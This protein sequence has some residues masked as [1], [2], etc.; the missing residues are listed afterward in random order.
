M[1]YR[2]SE[3]T[4]ERNSLRL[5]PDEEV[6]RALVAGDERAMEV[7]FARYYRMVMR[8]AL[9]IVRDPGEAQDV[10]QIVFTDF[11]RAAKLFDVDKGSLKTWLLQYAYGRSVNRKQSLK[12]RNFYQEN[13][14]DALELVPSHQGARFFNMELAEVRLLADQVLA[15]LDDKQ[16]SVIE[17]VCFRGLTMAETAV[18]L[19]DSIGN[20]HHAYYRGLEKLRMFL[21]SGRRPK[22]RS[23]PAESVIEETPLLSTKPLEQ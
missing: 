8:V 9:R 23:G 15:T 11:Y 13:D 6:V 18:A 14:S 3:E 16:R 4:I 20:I 1:S 19:G 2:S 17:S 5:L 10:V 21:K 7:L 22:Y 12:N